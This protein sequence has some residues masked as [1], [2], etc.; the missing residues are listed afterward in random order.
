MIADVAKQYLCIPGSSVSAE[1]VFST[2][3]DIVTAQGSTLKS[4]HI[5]Q[6]VFL[7][8]N[9]CVPHSGTDDE[10]TDEDE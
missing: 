1:R 9:V 6:L 3:G 5:D 7:H 4:E 2:A 8:K 10:E